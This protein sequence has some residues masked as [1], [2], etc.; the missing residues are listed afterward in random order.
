MKNSGQKY[1]TDKIQCTL[2]GPREKELDELAQ[3]ILASFRVCYNQWISASIYYWEAVLLHKR[4]KNSFGAIFT[5]NY[6]RSIEKL[7]KMGNCEGEFCKNM[8]CGEVNNTS[9]SSLETILNGEGVGMPEIIYLFVISRESM[10][11]VYANLIKKIIEKQVLGQ[12][13]Q[14][15]IIRYRLLAYIVKEVPEDFQ[16]EYVKHEHAKADAL[17]GIEALEMAERIGRLQL[18]MPLEY[19]EKTRNLRMRLELQS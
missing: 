1:L 18:K 11:E 8:S 9:M 13:F 6:Y 17:K 4:E 19:A 3:G 15:E 12:A 2:L 14:A 5:E 7:A 10:E 16:D